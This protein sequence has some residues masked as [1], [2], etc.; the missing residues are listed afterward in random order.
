MILTSEFED[1][2]VDPYS[3]LENQLFVRIGIGVY[4]SLILTIGTFL[5]IGIISYEKFGGDPQ[6]RGIQNQVNNN[7]NRQLLDF[8]FPILFHFS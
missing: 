5:H 2:F 6:K 3:L 4:F 8:R 7:N 1:T